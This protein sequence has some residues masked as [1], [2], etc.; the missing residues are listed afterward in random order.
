MTQPLLRRHI[1][2]ALLLAFLF[3]G[4]AEAQEECRQPEPVCAA[5]GSVFAI[6]GPGG[7]GSATRLSATELVTTR[8]L[9]ADV[10]EVELFL[11]SGE[12]IKASVVASAYEADLILLSAPGLPAGP[13]LDPADGPV[14]APLFTV[15]ADVSFGRIRAYDPGDILLAPADGHP[16]AR[17]HHTAYGQ[18]AHSG[19]ALVGADG[20]LAGIVAAGGDGR[21]EAIPAAAIAELRQKSGADFSAASDEIGGAI[22]I[23]MLN[24]DRHRADQTP[25]SDQEA[26][27]LA[28]SCSRSRNR[29]NMDLAAQVLGMKGRFDESIALFEAALEEDPNALNA[30][31]GLAVSYHLAAR[32]EE[33][34]PHLAFLMQH[35]P[36]DHQVLRLALQAGIWGG[37][38]ALAERAYERIETV[39]PQ[40]LPVAKRF[41]EN[42]PPRPKR[43]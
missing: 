5:R 16:F 20:R 18:P 38:R 26:S 9:I 2:A 42:P 25:L 34:I 17:L 40:M 8:H 35:L 37:D 12:R 28:T 21:F 13:A 15:G 10:T 30:R 39:N 32:Y 19:G 27:A 41:L 29:Q 6:S 36:D 14:R 24:L 22:R 3:S 23:C 1:A 43:R 31:M 4:S 33:E 11:E 7:I